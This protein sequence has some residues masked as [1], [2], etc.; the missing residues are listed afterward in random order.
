MNSPR[1][2]ASQRR[3]GLTIQHTFSVPLNQPERGLVRLNKQTIGCRIRPHGECVH[4]HNGAVIHPLGHQMQRSPA[5][6]EA[7]LPYRRGI[8][9]SSRHKGTARVARR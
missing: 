5:D 8:F 3:H 1:A 4:R 7:P 9:Y 2:R 6:T